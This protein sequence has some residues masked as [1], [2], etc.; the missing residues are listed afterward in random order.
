V[1]AAP[2]A[3][4]LTETVTMADLYARQGL[5]DNAVDIYEHILQRDPNNEAVRAK[6]DALLGAPASARP[7]AEEPREA[8]AEGE[9][10]PGPARN[11][12]VVKL[13]SWLAKVGR[14]EV[15]GV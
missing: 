1:A 14:K 3:E 5:T 7:S 10:E 6:R 2:L 4:D 15:S 12:K 9:P 13:E 11:P 8:E